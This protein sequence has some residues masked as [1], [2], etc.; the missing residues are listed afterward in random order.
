MGD[1]SVRH[2]AQILG[3]EGTFPEAPFNS[4]NTDS[5][6]A[7]D[8]QC[9]FALRGERY[10]G[11]DYVADALA[12]GALCAVVENSFHGPESIEHKLLKVADT[13]KALGDFA[14]QYRKKCGFKV[15]AITGSAGKTTTR[16]IA[17]HVLSR[18]FRIFT[19]PKNFNNEIGLP[20]T[21]LSADPAD[22]I[23]IAELGANHP[24]E[25]ANLSRIAKPNIA[26]VT[27]VY[28]SHLE[29]FGNIDTIAEEKLSIAQS[30]SNMGTLIIN[31]D[32]EDLINACRS[33]DIAF[34]SFGTSPDCDVRA[35]EINCRASS[36]QFN[37]DS[38]RV[39]AG[40]CGRGNVENALA[41]WAICRKFDISAADFAKAMVTTPVVA[42][43]LE[44]KR[45]GNVTVIDD[46]Y[47]A[48]PIS[49]RNALDVLLQFSSAENAR[50]VFICGDMAEL[51]N[52]SK[53]LHAEL[54][55]YIAKSNVQL[56]IAV[57]PMASVAA[58]AAKDAAEYDLL[59]QRFEGVD[60]ACDSLH[61]I[62]KDNDIVLVKGSRSATLEKAVEEL[63]TIFQNP[64]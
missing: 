48:N 3:T 11:H 33:K 15:V 4:V 52:Q 9:F 57:G 10:D 17:A 22:E 62:V 45:F 31:G 8:G 20:L 26:L 51:G 61:K 14:A 6:T 49:M 16:R 56:I 21:L 18:H 42:S 1:F 5:R 7:A 29:G 27:N 47:N 13:K 58:A 46:C 50:A 44:V 35:L 2:L 41:A 40:I 36:I 32:N 54:G 63:Q 43:R 39:T 28:P 53:Q 30:L 59:I 55:T 24:G 37:I 64:G 60:S 23:V 34:E 38:V 25:I 19:A 12:K